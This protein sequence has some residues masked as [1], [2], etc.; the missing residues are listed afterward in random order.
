MIE[1][2]ME[3]LPITVRFLKEYLDRI[4]D[5]ARMDLPVKVIL[6]IPSVGPRA[7]SLVTHVNFGYDWD[8]GLLLT[9][10]ESLVPRSEDQLA[11]Q[12]AHELLLFIATKPVKKES[13]E[14]RRAKQ[15]LFRL[16]KDQDYLDKVS[17]IFHKKGGEN[18]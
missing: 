3:Q 18:D 12:M 11:Y 4:S 5:K 14:I 13:Y 1:K 16:G 15:I 2:K 10:K 8:K 7:F 9:T 6:S 17:H